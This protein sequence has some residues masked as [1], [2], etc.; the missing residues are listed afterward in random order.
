MVCVPLLLC[1]N[2]QGVLYTIC[3]ARIY[4]IH[5]FEWSLIFMGT[6]GGHQPTC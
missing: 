4:L 5:I 3:L 6:D 1:C 2:K